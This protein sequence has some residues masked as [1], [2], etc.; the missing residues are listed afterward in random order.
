M[1][2]CRAPSKLF[3]RQNSRGPSRRQ[4][5]LHPGRARSAR[6]L[7]AK[8]VADEVRELGGELREVHAPFDHRLAAAGPDG[9][10]GLAPFHAEL[11]VAALVVPAEPSQHG[12]FGFHYILNAGEESFSRGNEESLALDEDPHL[13][14]RVGLLSKSYF[15]P[16]TTRRS[17]SFRSSSG[18]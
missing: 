8:L 10:E 1:R 17:R 11:A 6:A 12:K 4:R 5:P 9:E 7:S 16:G 3:P 15:R 2:C 14:A 18:C 13:R